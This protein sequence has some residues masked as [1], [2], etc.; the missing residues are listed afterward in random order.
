MDNLDKIESKVDQEPIDRIRLVLPKLEYLAAGEFSI[1]RLDM[2]KDII[3][4]L[5]KAE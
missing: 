4:E 1:L 2:L 5:K 3:A